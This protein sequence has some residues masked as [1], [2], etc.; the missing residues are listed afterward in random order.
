MKI[1]FTNARIMPVDGGV[2]TGDL[3]TENGKIVYMGETADRAAGV[4]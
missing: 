2:F 1:H 4:G 3:I